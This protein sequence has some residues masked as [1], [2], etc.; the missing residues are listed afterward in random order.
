MVSNFQININIVLYSRPATMTFVLFL[1]FI[2][3]EFT[4]ARV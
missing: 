3:T 4:L 2:E 1:L